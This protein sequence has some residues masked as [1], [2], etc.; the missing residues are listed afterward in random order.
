MT[1]LVGELKRRGA[2]RMRAPPSTLADKPS[3]RAG[4]NSLELHAPEGGV[5]LDQLEADV[6]SLV[7]APDNFRLGLAA[8]FGMNQTH[9]SMQREWCADNRHAARMADID[10]HRI[11]ALL[12]RFLVPFDEEFNFRNDAL[13]R[14]QASPTLLHSCGARVGVCEGGHE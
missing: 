3:K 8:T 14:A 6:P 9:A 10:G 12:R 4:Q 7:I 13:V 5:R 11:G 2:R 1:G